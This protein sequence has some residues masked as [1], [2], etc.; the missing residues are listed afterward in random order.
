MGENKQ[1][2]NTFYTLGAMLFHIHC[3]YFCIESVVTI[4]IPI[5]QVRKLG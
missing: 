1:L 2:L 4:I 3:S 5:L